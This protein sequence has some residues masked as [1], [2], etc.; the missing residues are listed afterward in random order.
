MI[1][2]TD[3]EKIQDDISKTS[4]ETDDKMAQDEDSTGVKRKLYSKVKVFIELVL[5][6]VAIN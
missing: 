1:D 3:E 2:L 4:R 6:G 5:F